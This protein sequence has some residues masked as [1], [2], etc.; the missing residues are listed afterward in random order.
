MQSEMEKELEQLREENKC[1]R[2]AAQR[3]SKV[4]EVYADSAWNLSGMLLKQAQN[5]D[6]QCAYW[7]ISALSKLASSHPQRPVHEVL[8]LARH[9]MPTAAKM[10]ADYVADK[11]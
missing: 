8:A 10:Y 1:L 7:F 3:V 9:S 6:E 4:D 2:K 5:R 11:C